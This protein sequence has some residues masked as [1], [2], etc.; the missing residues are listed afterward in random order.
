MACK[1]F[2]NIRIIIDCYEGY[3]RPTGLLN[4]SITYSQYKSCNMWKIL[5]RCM[6]TSLVNFVSEPWGERI[7]DEEITEW[8]GLLDLLGPGDMIMA[9]KGMIRIQEMVV[10]LLNVQ[11]W[12]ESKHKQIL[13]SA[14][15]I[16]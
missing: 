5:V 1:N 15:R 4:S 3:Q 8:S 10:T 9:D 12:L 7:S 2:S 6:P 14:A 16:C 11:P 13:V